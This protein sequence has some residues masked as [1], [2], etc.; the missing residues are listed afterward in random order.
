MPLQH[1]LLPL[2]PL[3]QQLKVELPLRL[4]QPPPLELSPQEE[5]PQLQ[6][7]LLLHLVLS[8]CQP[9]APGV[10]A[11][12]MPMVRPGFPATG[13]TPGA[14]TNV[15]ASPCSTRLCITVLVQQIARLLCNRTKAIHHFL[16]STP[17]Q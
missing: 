16:I 10:G 1:L 14:P 12:M 5:M 13:A 8:S 15:N 6:L 3:Q 9:G 7:L 11:P 4:P 2:K 17:I